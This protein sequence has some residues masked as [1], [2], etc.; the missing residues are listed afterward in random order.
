MNV[1]ECRRALANLGPDELRERRGIADVPADVSHCEG[2]VSR[3]RVAFSSSNWDDEKQVG[4][5]NRPVG[6]LDYQKAGI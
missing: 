3:K 2:E 4:E 6:G 5:V 1:Q